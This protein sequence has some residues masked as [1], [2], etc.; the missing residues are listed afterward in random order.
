MHTLRLLPLSLLAL[1]PLATPAL[2]AQEPPSERRSDAAVPADIDAARAAAWRRFQADHEGPWAVRWSPAAGTPKAI[3]GTGL[4]IADWRENTL[5]EA[6]RHAQRTL[7]DHA[8]LLGLGNSDFRESIGARMGRTWSFVFDQYFA[9]LPVLGGRADVRV[10]SSGRIA[11]F[12]STAFAMPVGFVTTPGITPET[13]TVAAWQALGAAPLASANARAPKAPRLVIW[14]DAEAAARTSVHLAWEVTVHDVAADGSGTIGRSYVDAQTAQVLRFVNDKHACGPECA[15]GGTAAAAADTAP[16]PTPLPIATTTTV[17]AYVNTG[18]AP[19]M[20]ATPVPLARLT[21]TVPGIGPVTTDALGRFTVNITAPVTVTVGNLDGRHF[22]PIT[23]PNAPSTTF[24]ITPGANGSVTLLLPVSSSGQL[25]HT[26]CA[27]WID[28]T[29]EWARSILGNTPQLAT[30]DNVAVNVNIAS[31]CNAYYDPNVNSVNFYAAGGG[32]VNSAYST[33]IAHEWGHGLDDRYGG[34]SQTQGLSEGWADIV[35]M[36]VVDD[37]NVGLGFSTAGVSMRS[38]QNMRMYPTGTGVHEWGETWMGFAWKVRQNLAATMSRSAAIAI[39]NDIVLGTIVAN[40]TDQPDAVLE[41]F[42]ADDDDGNLATGTPHDAALVAAAFAHFLPFPSVVGPINDYCVGAIQIFNGLNGPFTNQGSDGTLSTWS[43]G[44]AAHERDVWFR[45]DCV[46]QGTLTF[47]TCGLT[48]LDTKLQVRVGSCSGPVIACENLNTTCG[49]Q[50]SLSFGAFPNTYYLQV[51]ADT[52]GSFRVQ[53]TPPPSTLATSVVHGTGCGA[54]SKAVYEAFPSQQF[55]LAGSSLKLVNLGT[56]YV[57]QPGGAFLPLT[58]NSFQ[59]SHGDDTVL[60]FVLSFPMPYPGGTVQTLEVCSNGFVSAGS[61]NGTSANPT[62][63]SWLNSVRTRW[64]AWHDFDPSAAGSGKIHYDFAGTTAY[65]TWDGVYTYSTTI[66]ARWQI[67]FDQVTGDVTMVWQ[68]WPTVLG[69]TLVGVS[70]A[71]QNL[72]LGSRDISA[73][74]AGGFR[75]FPYNAQP[76]ALAGTLPT[77]GSNLILTT[78]NFPSTGPIGLQMLGNVGYTNGISLAPLGMPGCTQWSEYLVINTIVAN[79][80]TAQYSLG[81]PSTP[82]L[83][84]YA[85]KAQSAA[86][87]PTYNAFQFVVSNG[88][89]MTVGS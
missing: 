17:M 89:W 25:A 24:T 82:A 29:N 66:P 55:D 69:Q 59:T 42:L 61:G 14:A 34:I 21:L 36:Y 56:H 10:S 28:R 20:F 30:A 23:G 13:A 3:Y 81:I 58:G 71:G 38:G 26:N 84:G 52:Y 51:G 1:W 39:S 53:V 73:T 64:G 35:A 46:G 67:Q 68:S 33:V 16:A 65:V 77:L 49:Q 85:L 76:L 47:S 88:V 9:G 8:D 7:A 62:A 72:D 12:G 45:Y 86:I 31:T 40:A 87:A 48:A 74:L 15:H 83:V 2:R 60:N 6:R 37:P 75:T 18:L 57:A 19:S 32:C 41:V 22:Q 11:M 80:G 63:S 54:A 70:T 50:T 27:Y 44:D 4:P 5:D 79:G 43:C 78:T